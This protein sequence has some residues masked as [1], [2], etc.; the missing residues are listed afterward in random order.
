MAAD[1]QSRVSGSSTKPPALLIGY[2]ITR[3]WCLACAPEGVTL[4]GCDVYDGDD[5]G[6]PYHCD[7][8]GEPLVAGEDEGTRSAR[9]GDR[10]QP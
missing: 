9:P 3:Y 1:P 5:Y 4:G 6:V 2:T 10:E 7:D 8:C